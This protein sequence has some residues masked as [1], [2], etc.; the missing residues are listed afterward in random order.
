MITYPE[1][2]D[3]AVLANLQSLGVDMSAPLLIEFA[4]DAPDEA[5][6]HAIE[7]VLVAQK[8]DTEVYY[9]SGEPDDDDDELEDGDEEFG[10]SWTVYANV[11]MVPLYDEIIRIQAEL[12]QLAKP[13]GGR[14]DGW[15]VM[16]DD[17]SDDS[18]P[19]EM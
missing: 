7:K 5:T 10:P 6:A 18:L 4:V 2:A 12:D 15:G 1:D 17:D 8:Y 16:M 14:G 13:H 9:D 19:D 11:T 3:G